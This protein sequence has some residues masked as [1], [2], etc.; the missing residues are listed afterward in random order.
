[1]GTPSCSQKEVVLEDC[2]I[3]L[4]KSVSVLISDFLTHLP[5]L[6]EGV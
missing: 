3:P 6:N 4:N 2:R 5:P 1:V